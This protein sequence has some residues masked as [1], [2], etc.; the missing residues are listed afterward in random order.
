MPIVALLDHPEF[1]ARLAA[2]HLP[3]WR[4]AHPAWTLDDWRVEFER[5]ALGALPYTLL[6]LD[7]AGELL[8]SASLIEDDMDGCNTYTP[9]LA[10]VLVLPAA[11]GLGTGGALI[12]AIEAEAARRSFS[13]LYLFTEDQQALY[14][15]RGWAPLEECRF[16]GKAV[17]IMHKAL[18]T[19]R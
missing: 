8:G 18:P 6:A 2:L 19:A 7:D 4:A 5:H 15:R 3:Q 13:T 14:R 16:K 11:R 10:N 17:S 9:W 12:A 1:I